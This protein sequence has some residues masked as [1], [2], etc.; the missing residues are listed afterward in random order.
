MLPM[1]KERSCRSHNMVKKLNPSTEP[2][3]P[4]IFPP[5]R[6]LQV[7]T[8]RRR[9]CPRRNLLCKSLPTNCTS[10]QIEVFSDGFK[11]LVAGSTSSPTKSSVKLPD[12]VSSAFTPIWISCDSPPGSI[13]PSNPIARCVLLFPCC[14]IS[15]VTCLILVCF[16]LISNLVAAWTFP[17][18]GLSP[19]P[20]LSMEFVVVQ[21]I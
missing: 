4:F 21:G 15:V 14:A 3:Y 7:S 2:P 12:R 5:R 19:P 13:G 8:H 6:P 17:A 10:R 20:K 18:T 1:L 9:F 11:A 16:K